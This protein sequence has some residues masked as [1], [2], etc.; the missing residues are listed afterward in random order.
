MW[1]KLLISFVALVGAFFGIIVLPI[2]AAIIYNSNAELNS[3]WYMWNTISFYNWLFL[4]FASA[5]PIY[6]LL[7]LNLNCFGK[8][9]KPENEI[10]VSPKKEIDS[11]ERGSNRGSPLKMA[12]MH[13]Q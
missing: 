8:C 3:V 9:A 1:L 2:I 12:P 6:R 13:E 5:K 4:L 7:K 11:E 10:E